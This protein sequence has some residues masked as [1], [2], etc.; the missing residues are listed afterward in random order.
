MLRTGKDIVKALLKD[1]WK[2]E[3]V[4]GSHHFMTKEGHRPEII[5][6]HGNKD[7][8]KGLLQ[9]ILKRTGLK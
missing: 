1:G 2:L 4:E 8:P 7:I 5:P 3:R 6:V 9:K